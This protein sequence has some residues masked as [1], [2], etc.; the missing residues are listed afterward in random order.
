M[1]RLCRRGL[2]THPC[3]QFTNTDEVR[4]PRALPGKRGRAQLLPIVRNDQ[5]SQSRNQ[6]KTGAQHPCGLV[7][8]GGPLREQVDGDVVSDRTRLLD[9]LARRAGDRLMATR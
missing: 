2:R 6:L 1:Q 4:R 8:D 5:P 9:A 7:G 3:P